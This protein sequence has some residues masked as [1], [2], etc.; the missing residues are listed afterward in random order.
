MDTQA[1][2]TLL[3]LIEAVA[4]VTDSEAEDLKPWSVHQSN[5]DDSRSQ[6]VKRF[7]G[8]PPKLE[9]RDGPGGGGDQVAEGIVVG[10]ADPLFDRRLAVNR[11]RM[12]QIERDHPQVI[13]AE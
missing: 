11:N 2:L 7:R 12:A 1:Q 6:H 5:R 10:L 9:L 4:E 13:Q 8:N 3:D